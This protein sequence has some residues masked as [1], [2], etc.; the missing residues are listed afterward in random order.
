MCQC[1]RG[2]VNPA[3]LLGLVLLVALV[4]VAWLAV[5]NRASGL[6]ERPGIESEDFGTGVTIGMA[7]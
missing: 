4:G 2:Q 6:P 3:F 7:L 1:Q 5:G